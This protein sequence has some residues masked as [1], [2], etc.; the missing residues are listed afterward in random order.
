MTELTPEELEEKQEALK[1][2]K[3][4]V[5]ALKGD[6]TATATQKREAANALRQA[7]R[8]ADGQEVLRGEGEG[9]AA[10]AAAGQAPFFD[11]SPYARERKGGGIGKVR[12]HAKP[13]LDAQ[14][15]APYRLSRR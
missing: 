7:N 1:A 4:R 10:G 15:G 5:N 2:A 6:T 14:V 3:E 9:T 13:L 12:T 8:A 11:P